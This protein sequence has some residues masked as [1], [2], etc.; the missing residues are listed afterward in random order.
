[1]LQK[2]N[3]KDF[4]FSMAEII[5][6]FRHSLKELTWKGGP[7]SAQLPLRHALLQCAS[8]Q[9]LRVV[10]ENLEDAND[11]FPTVITGQ[12][13]LRVIGFNVGQ[14]L[15]HVE[16]SI[17]PNIQSLDLS[18]N[19]NLTTLFTKGFATLRSISL[20]ET[21]IDDRTLDELLRNAV[22]LEEL[23]VSTCVKLVRP[24]VRSESLLS[25]RIA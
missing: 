16:C 10:S 21:A 25:L 14:H 6:S 19:Y 15:T 8:L 22:L 3:V 18:G 5:C 4:S 20:A 12:R 9:K 1:M 24:V 17:P 11:F 23:D 13:L 7:E 2:L